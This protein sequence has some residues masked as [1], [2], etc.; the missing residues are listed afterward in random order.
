[1]IGLVLCILAFTLTWRL[2]RRS[3]GAGIGCVAVFGYAYGF[4]RG[5]FLS[6]LTYVSFDV[7]LCA[8]YLA[9][10]TMPADLETRRR[11]RRAVPWAIAL[12][13]WPFICALYSPFLPNTQSPMIQLVGIRAVAIMVPMLVLGAQLT[14]PDMDK[15]SIVFA[16]LNLAALGLGIYEYFYGLEG[17]FEFNTSTQI[18]LSSKDIT[19]GGV[20]FHRI[21]SSFLTAQHYGLTLGLSVPF[22]LHSVDS[23]RGWRRVL[24]WSGLAA[25]LIGVFLC[26]TRLP[27][28]SLVVAAVVTLFSMRL[29]PTTLLAF[30]IVVGITFYAVANLERFQRFMTMK[31]TAMVESR[32]VLSNAGFLD[33]ITRLPM[34]AGLASG[35]TPVPLM[36]SASKVPSPILLENEYGNMVVEEGVIGFALWVGMILLAS[37]SRVRL[38][39]LTTPATAI[40]LRAIVVM[41]WLMAMMAAGARDAVPSG[42]LLLLLTGACLTV[43]PNEEVSA[44]RRPLGSR[45]VLAA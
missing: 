39:F 41:S 29:R 35:F 25:A 43:V 16:C 17:L 2:G 10:F 45:T 20:N 11:A 8:L 26:G 27:V 4:L 30:G 34:G 23:S 37:L 36:L 31:D 32:F 18:A 28:C 22:V 38:T 21:P 14:R 7:A 40:N 15:L 33:A 13:S 12:T 19:E 9:R 5:V 24:S 42:P 6:P 3:L 1:M 44:R